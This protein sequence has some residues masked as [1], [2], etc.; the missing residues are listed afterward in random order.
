[1]RHLSEIL[2]LADEGDLGLWCDLL[3]YRE[4]GV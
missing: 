4:F 2:R 1:M 3:A